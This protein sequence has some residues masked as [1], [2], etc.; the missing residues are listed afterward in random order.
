MLI[1]YRDENPTTRTAVVTILLIAANIGIF[2]YELLGKT[3]YGAVTAQFGLIPH[4]IMQGKN[5]PDS[6]WIN[7]YLTIISYMFLHGGLLHLLFNML[8]LWIFGNNIEDRMSPVRFLFFY[9]LTGAISGIAFAISAPGMNTPLVGASGAISGILGAY[10]F[11][12][13]FAKIRVLLFIF[14]VRMPALVFIIIWF[15]MQVFGV[16][17][18]INESNIAWAAHISGFVAGV[19]LFKFFTVNRR[20]INNSVI[21]S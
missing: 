3:G 19:I 5:L 2:V 8:F 4:E 9:L 6:S 10:L 17:D 13:P 12:F 21:I 16:L 1:P 20:K 15:I 18:T 14:R 11:M 7:P